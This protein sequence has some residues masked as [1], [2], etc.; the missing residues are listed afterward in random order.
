MQ[1]ILEKPFVTRLNKPANCLDR[2]RLVG[3]HVKIALLLI[4]ADGMM[5]LDNAN[6]YTLMEQP[7]TREQRIAP[8]D[9]ESSKTLAPDVGLWEGPVLYDKGGG[10]VLY[11]ILIEKALQE[12]SLY[13]YD[14]EYTLIQRRRCVSGKRHGKKRK[15]KDQKTPEGIFFNTKTFRDDEI[16]IFGDRA[17][18]LNYPDIFDELE[19]NGGSGIFIHGTNR[20]LD[21]YSSNGCLVM[22]N[23]ELKA[24]DTRIDFKTTPVIIGERLPYTFT[25]SKRDFNELLP[26]LKKAMLPKKYAGL[27]ASIDS[28]IVL[29]M[30]ERVVALG[31][32]I[33][34]KEGGPERIR[35]YSRLYLAEPG[36]HFL[37]L[38]K[39]EWR[40]EKAPITVARAET[41]KKETTRINPIQPLQIV[42]PPPEPPARVK[43]PSEPTPPEEPPAAAPEQV[44]SATEPRP[45]APPEPTPTVQPSPVPEKAPQDAKSTDERQ[46][47][48]LPET[49]PS[50]P[51]DAAADKTSPVVAPETLASSKT[52]AT[53]DVSQKTPSPSPQ[54]SP[55]EQTA[56]LEP[57]PSPTPRPIALVPDTI[58]M[59]EPA[60]SDAS[61]T[62]ESKS[63]DTE[64][65]AQAEPSQT[66][67]TPTHIKNLVESWRKAWEEERLDDYIAC[68]HPDFRGKDKNLTEW[69]QYKK[70][71]NQRNKQIRV[72]ISDVKVYPQD[73]QVSVIFRQYYR[74][75]T[76][77]AGGFKLLEFKKAD[78]LWKIHREKMV[79]SSQISA[80][81]RQFQN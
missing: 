81:A 57:T 9:V 42:T 45:S 54:P 34:D 31:E 80:I 72:K 70:I 11:L 35:G 51:P 39:R 19:G 46:R 22:R 55:S 24:L 6:A 32:L 47:A 12:L 66:E 30:Q 53:E 15:E 13:R 4:I 69:R 64:K 58:D 38:V 76:F 40:E 37:V 18:G 62:T 77:K 29:G 78:G 59:P 52:P 2:R 8:A 49:Q 17:F 71:L 65:A 36:D 61:E 26:F 50:T 1:P 21:A 14:G 75:D 44:A 73:H 56:A 41:R 3:F 16:T 60:S 27:D 28:L 67:S 33:I 79:N 20:P 5:M 25:A 23:A 10:R 74:S 7:L 63:P 68:Y 43:E 48:S